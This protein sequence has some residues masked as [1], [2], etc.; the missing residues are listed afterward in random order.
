MFAAN[1]VGN[2][3]GEFLQG[4]EATGKPNSTHHPNAPVV[5]LG[6]STI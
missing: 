4:G 1:E 6:G 2:H 3:V 5:V